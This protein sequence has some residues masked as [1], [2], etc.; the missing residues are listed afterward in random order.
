MT[1]VRIFDI[2]WETDGE[3]PALPSEL[4][5]TIANKDANTPY[6]LSFLSDTFGWLVLDMKWEIVD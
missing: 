1:T 3:S 2:K 4:K 5:I 6:L